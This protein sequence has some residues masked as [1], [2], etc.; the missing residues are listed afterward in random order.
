MFIILRS[1]HQIVISEKFANHNLNN[2]I[3]QY[4]STGAETNPLF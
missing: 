3:S 2:A 4:A 1:G